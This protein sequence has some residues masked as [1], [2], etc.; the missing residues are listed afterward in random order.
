MYKYIWMPNH[1]YVVGTENELREMDLEDCLV[2]HITTDFNRTA[3]YPDV[4]IKNGMIKVHT[5]L[6]PN[7][8]KSYLFNCLR[9]IVKTLTKVSCHTIIVT[10]EEEI[11]I[12]KLYSIC[13]LAMALNEKKVDPQSFLSSIG[14]RLIPNTRALNTGLHIAFPQTK[15]DA[16]LNQVCR[17]LAGE[18]Y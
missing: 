18:D 12:K 6:R 3:H 17:I 2:L 4:L 16:K 15:Y 5:Y 7:Q 14:Q 10:C 9:H 8:S 1:E 11:E 13:F